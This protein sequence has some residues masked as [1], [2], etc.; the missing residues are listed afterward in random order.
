MPAGA[1]DTGKAPPPAPVLKVLARLAPELRRRRRAAAETIADARWLADA[2]EWAVE[3]E[4]WIARTEELLSIDL[5]SI[6]DAELAEQVRL[7]L[8]TT[9]DMIQRHFSLV[10]ASVAVGRL[11]VAGQRWGL[12][13]GDIVPA[14][15]GSSPSSSASRAPLAELAALTS[16]RTDLRTADDLRTVSP[17]ATELIDRYLASYGWRPLSADVE[18]PTLAEFPDR[19]VDL[20]R[21]QAVAAR[22]VGLHDPFDDLRDGVPVAD[23]PEFDRLVDEARECYASLDD[24]SGILASTIGVARRVVLEVGRRAFSHDTLTRPDDVFNLTPAELL[25]LAA[26]GSSVAAPVMDERRQ[27]RRLAT[28]QPPPPVIGGPMVPPPDPSVFPGALGELAAAVT[29]YLDLKFTAHPDVPRTEPTGSLNVD[30][31]PP[32]GGIAVVAGAVV[33]RIV[34][35]SEPADALERIEPGDILVCPYTTAAHNAI[36]PMLGGVVTQFGGPLGHTTVMAH[37]FDIPAVVDTG[38]LPLHLD[39]RHGELVAHLRR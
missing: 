35:S 34:V 31:Q 9:G 11:I 14:L 22:D 6:D 24:N 13:P 20:V 18:A 4:G 19:L 2:R 39:G 1:P 5:A 15:R 36:F 26:G 25:T 30:G 37:E 38:S 28:Q 7:A 3:R 32:V 12:T 10:G 33:G 17:R 29:A 21:S 23:R 8:A 27:L 16:D